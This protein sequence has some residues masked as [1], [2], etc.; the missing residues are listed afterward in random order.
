[1]PRELSVQGHGR[2][3]VLV[4]HGPPVG[5]LRPQLVDSLG[6]ITELSWEALA[7]DERVEQIT[8]PN[9]VTFGELVLSERFFLDFTGRIRLPDALAS[10]AGET[11]RF[12]GRASDFGPNEV[13]AGGVQARSGF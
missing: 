4:G 1:M 3:T 5:E 13:S 11:F 6:A 10:R 12:E 2:G 9:P 7:R 8:A